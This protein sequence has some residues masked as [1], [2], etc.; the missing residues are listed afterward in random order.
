VV[1]A[2]TTKWL[3]SKKWSESGTEGCDA[4]RVCLV[5]RPQPAKVWH[6]QVVQNPPLTTIAIQAPQS[7]VK[8]DI[9]AVVQ[10]PTTVCDNGVPYP[11]DVI[12]ATANNEK[13]DVA[14]C[15]YW[16][17]KYYTSP[18]YKFGTCDLLLSNNEMKSNQDVYHV[19]AFEYHFGISEC[20]GMIPATN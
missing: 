13:N 5:P 12:V 11:L 10:D 3:N 6:C 19:Y 17:G 16:F 1:E 4:G 8:T 9:P 7:V 20:C 2:A 18:M 15:Q 14:N